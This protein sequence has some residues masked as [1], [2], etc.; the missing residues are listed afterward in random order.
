MKLWK[1]SKHS[2]V[3]IFVVGIACLTAT[4]CVTPIY[5]TAEVT[6]GRSLT[7]GAG[8]MGYGYWL[9]AGLDGSYSFDEAWGLHLDVMGREAKTESFAFLGYVSSVVPIRETSGGTP[10]SSNGF[11]PFGGIGFQY[12][13]AERPSLSLQIIGGIPQFL[14]LGLLAGIPM[15]EREIIITGVVFYP[16]AMV[17]EETFLPP[18]VSI[19]V[20]PVKNLHLFV[21]ANPFTLISESDAWDVSAGVGYTVMRREIDRERY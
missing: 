21:G 2:I 8:P 14:S 15:R 7:A 5:H 4:S 19:T 16:A 1:N 12:E 18:T 9:P 11:Y 6:P 17:T 10:A 13:F 3:V 20:H